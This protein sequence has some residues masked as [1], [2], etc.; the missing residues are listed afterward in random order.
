MHLKVIKLNIKRTDTNGNNFSVSETCS[1]KNMLYPFSKD[2][3]YET[4]GRFTHDTYQSYHS[5]VLA[6][7][8]KDITVPHQNYHRDP[9][10]KDIS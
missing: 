2:I 7:A 5:D 6:V 9:Q 1:L 4:H 8:D 3:Y 10:C